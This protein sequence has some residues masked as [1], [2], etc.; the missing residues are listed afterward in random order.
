MEYVRSIFLFMRESSWID[1]LMD[2]FGYT[3]YN[4]T[5]PDE[6]M[7]DEILVKFRHSSWGH[8]LEDYKRDIEEVAGI[9]FRTVNEMRKMRLVE[10][11]TENYTLN[12]DVADKIANMI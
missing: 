1:T 10:V 4:R 3:T 2:D 12:F 5:N 6:T 7:L 11:L 9:E 8:Q